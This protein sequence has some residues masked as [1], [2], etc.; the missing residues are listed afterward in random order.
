MTLVDKV[1][2]VMSAVTSHWTTGRNVNEERQMSLLKEVK[3]T[4]KFQ[5]MVIAEER[6]YHALIKRWTPV[7]WEISPE[8]EKYKK[9]SVKPEISD[10]Q[11]NFWSDF[12]WPS[13]PIPLAAERSFLLFAFEL[14][15]IS[16]LSLNG[17]ILNHLYRK[18]HPQHRTRVGLRRPSGSLSG[19][20]LTFTRTEL[21]ASNPSHYPPEVELI[22]DILVH[23][24]TGNHWYR[25]S[26]DWQVSASLRLALGR[27]FAYPIRLFLTTMFGNFFCSTNSRGLLWKGDMADRRCVSMLVRS[28]AFSSFSGLYI[29]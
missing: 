8:R 12:F 7:W 26:L 18:W 25:L 11:L 9:P 20:G 6:R 13:Y 28:L 1:L 27:E 10:V 17:T 5:F 15:L 21:C 29:T 2:A 4:K 23:S 16:S 3:E 14:L 19:H 22:L 24:L